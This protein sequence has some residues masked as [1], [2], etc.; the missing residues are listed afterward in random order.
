M[1]STLAPLIDVDDTGFAARTDNAPNDI[2]VTI[3]NFLMLGECPATF[4]LIVR[5]LEITL[6][7]LRYKGKVT[8][9]KVL[10]LFPALAHDR[11]VSGK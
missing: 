5:S 9:T 11:S 7:N 10:P 3:I 8:W 6:I 2:L 1:L 4:Q